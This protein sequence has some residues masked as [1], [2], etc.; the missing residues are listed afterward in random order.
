M[1]K[2]RSARVLLVPALFLL[3]TG[4]VASRTLFDPAETAKIDVAVLDALEE[5]AMI[6]VIVKMKKQ[7]D[8]ATIERAKLP[9]ADRQKQVYDALRNVAMENQAEIVKLLETNSATKF[10]R[11]YI[12]NLIA[13]FNADAA[14]VRTLAAR[15]DVEKIYGNPTVALDRPSLGD[16]VELA[17]TSRGDS[18]DTI[19]DNILFTKAEQVWQKY[20]KAGEGIVIA[21]QDTGVQFDHPALIN[22]YRGKGGEHDYNWHDA[23]HAA[24]P[25]G[26]GNNCGYDLKTPCDDGD[27]GT[28]T[29]GTVVGSDG[30]ENVIG[31]A[32][33]A[34]WIA[35][36]NMDGGA[37]TPASYIE[38]FEWLLAP[39]A[40]GA[41]P[42]RDGRT[43]KAPHI[44]NNSWGCPTSEGCSSDVTAPAMASMKAAGI[45][46]VV[47]AGNEGPGCSTIQ[48]AP[49]WHSGLTLSVGAYDH[50]RGQI[51]GFSSRGPSAFD[52]QIGPDLVAPG[53]NIKSAVTGG[54]YEQNGWSGTSMA[55]PHVAGAAALLWSVR[56]EL[57]GDI[58]RTVALFRQSATAK[59]STETCGGVAGSAHPNNTYGMGILDIG[60]AIELAAGNTD[61][62]NPPAPPPSEKP[63]SVWPKI[64]G[65]K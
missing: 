17:L 41:D 10:R 19:G 2:L 39:Y 42:M 40:Y 63:K 1:S 31:M 20:G 3:A 26:G 51:A 61:L 30:G 7:A 15:S 32:P 56:P 55:G 6:P 48:D 50:R 54:R 64:F 59:S 29:V 21:G 38:C 60:R 36:R 53:V 52:S 44:I 16:R 18:P 8:L 33:K 24:T 46:V 57:I 5:S 47:S 12:A 34:Q 23:I 28:H 49:A 27:H 22:Q 62:P 11:F 35:C 37:G 65:R 45:L 25:A 13:V 4:A 14:L 43:D 9:R 58:D